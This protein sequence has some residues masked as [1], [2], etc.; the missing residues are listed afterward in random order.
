MLAAAPDQVDFWAAKAQNLNSI[1][2]QLSGT[3]IRKVVKV[4]ELTKVRACAPRARGPLSVVR[5]RA[6]LVVQ[7]LPERMVRLTRNARRWREVSP[8]SCY[9][10]CGCLEFCCGSMLVSFLGAVCS[11]SEA[12]NDGWSGPKRGQLLL[13]TLLVF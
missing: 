12:G 11:S 7:H 13:S 9:G 8:V 2:E 4:L 3:K 5:N 1:Y 6:R 10:H